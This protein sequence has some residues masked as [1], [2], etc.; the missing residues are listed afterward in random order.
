M[1][2]SNT[3]N[4]KESHSSLNRPTRMSKRILKINSLTQKNSKSCTKRLSSSSELPP[5]FINASN[6]YSPFS[7]N[8]NKTSNQSNYAPTD[9]YP[10][11]TKKSNL[12]SNN[13]IITDS[14]YPNISEKSSPKYTDPYN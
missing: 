1:D 14:T 6:M 9:A 2:A 7:K 12:N 4:N 5:P 13:D 3:N 8:K 10:N 11:K